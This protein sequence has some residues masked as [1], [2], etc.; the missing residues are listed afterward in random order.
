MIEHCKTLLYTACKNDSILIDKNTVKYLDFHLM[1]L[2]NNIK[3]QVTFLSYNIDIS[4]LVL[5]VVVVFVM[6]PWNIMPNSIFADGS[7]PP[8]IHNKL[9]IDRSF[10]SQFKF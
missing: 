6:V 5:T 9:F 1:L 10:C 7:Q 2:T 3:L 4:L 8:F